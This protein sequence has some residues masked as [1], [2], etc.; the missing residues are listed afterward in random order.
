MLNATDVSIECAEYEAAQDAITAAFES[1]SANDGCRA[2]LTDSVRVKSITW[3]N[4]KGK[5]EFLNLEEI[6][7]GID[8]FAE[9]EY[10]YSIDKTR[11]LFHYYF[12]FKPGD[13]DITWEIAGN[14]GLALTNYEASIIQWIHIDDACKGC[15][16]CN[17]NCAGCRERY[18]PEGAADLKQMLS[19]WLL[20]GLS[21][22]VMSSW[23]V[24]S[25]R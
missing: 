7:A 16:G 23:S 2:V 15:L 3:I 8:A 6:A 5:Y 12:L 24:V 10:D 14:D 22:L 1:V 18:I 9:G 21:V 11:K 13:Y 20:I 17:S 19:D 25:K 4:A